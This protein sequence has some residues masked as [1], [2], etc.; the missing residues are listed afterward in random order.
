MKLIATMPIYFYPSEYAEGS[1]DRTTGE[2]FIEWYHILGSLSVS[3]I[4][5]LAGNRMRWRLLESGAFDDASKAKVVKRFNMRIFVIVGC[6]L[7]NI[8]C[9]LALFGWFGDGAANW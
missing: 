7:L 3:G 6:N 8:F 1:L 5:F 2:D 4:T 9:V